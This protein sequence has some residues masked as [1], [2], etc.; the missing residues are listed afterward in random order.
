MAGSGSSYSATYTMTDSDTEGVVPFSVSFSDLAGNN[1]TA[2]T[3]TSNSSSVT[4]DKTAPA[5]PSG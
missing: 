4:F 2:V 5:V 3:A 1:G